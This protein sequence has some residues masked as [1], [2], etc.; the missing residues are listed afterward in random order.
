MQWQGCHSF[1]IKKKTNNSQGFWGKG[2]GP[3]YINDNFISIAILKS[4]LTTWNTAQII[5]LGF[6]IFLNL[7]F[8]VSRPD[9]GKNSRFSSH[10]FQSYLGY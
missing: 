10:C 3:D 4:T 8:K 7:F 5:I 9:Y 2:Q 1:F 6:T